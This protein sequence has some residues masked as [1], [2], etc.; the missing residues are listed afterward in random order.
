ML[1]Y[2]QNTSRP[3]ISMAVHQTARFSNNPMLSHEKSIMRIGQYLL[4][5]R[6]G[7]II[8][9]PDKSKG[10]ECYVD[11]E[12]AGGW[13]Q[14]DANNADNVLSRT[15]YII[16]YAN[17]PILWVSRLQTEIALSTPKAEYIAL[18]QALQDVIPLITLL[19]EI[20]KVFPICVRTPTFVCK[21]HEDNQSCITM[22]TSQK[23]TP[24]TKHIALKYHH[25]CSHVKRG[26]IQISYCP[27]TEQKADLL[28]KPLADDLFFKLQYMLSGW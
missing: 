25:F 20:D 1:S 18:S 26:A 23:F 22:A 8:Y 15:G 16:M 11:T 9:K 24:R 6:K 19:K 2:L 12:F 17:C 21:V 4:D 28:T 5:T 7:G 3:E 14:A 10:L 13:S 27:T